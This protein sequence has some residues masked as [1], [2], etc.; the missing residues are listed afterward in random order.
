MI[1]TS[2]V[3]ERILS[4]PQVKAWYERCGGRNG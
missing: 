4:W 2:D 3:A 1:R